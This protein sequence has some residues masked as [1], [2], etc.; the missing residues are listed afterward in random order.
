MLTHTN[1]KNNMNQVLIL[2]PIID[3]LARAMVD[4]MVQNFKS[5]LT[6]TGFVCDRSSYI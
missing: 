5:M 4:S 1:K 2:W 6:H 3:L